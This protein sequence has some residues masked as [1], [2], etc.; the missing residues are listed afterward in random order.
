MGFVDIKDMVKS[1]G[2]IEDAST[3]FS[4]DLGVY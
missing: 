1:R 4:Y 3:V 2:K